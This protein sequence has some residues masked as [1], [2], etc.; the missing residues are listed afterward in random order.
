MPLLD[1]D[2]RILMVCLGFPR[3]TETWH[4]AM[5]QAADSLEKAGQKLHFHNK[6]RRGNFRTLSVGISFGGGQTHPKIL[7]QH[8]CN[9]RILDDLIKEPAFERLSG[10]TSGCL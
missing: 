9:K 6:N 4:D 10:F 2:G 1:N 8:P 7:R 5:R 3:G